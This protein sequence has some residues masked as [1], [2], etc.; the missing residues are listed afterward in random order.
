MSIE[1]AFWAR[2]ERKGANECWP[3][4]GCI[5]HDG[6]GQF[7]YN[8]QRFIA[9]RFSWALAN[10][11]QPDGYVCHSC[12]NPPCVNPAHLW[13]GDVLSNTRDMLSKGRQRNQRKTHCSRGHAF[14]EANTYWHRGH[15]LCRACNA[16]HVAALKARRK[17]VDQ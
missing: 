4:K 11:R 14:D 1:Q 8:K 15:R 16:M 12:D 17:A 7:S 10:A 6:Y 13:L 5:R 2:V 3:W 9:S